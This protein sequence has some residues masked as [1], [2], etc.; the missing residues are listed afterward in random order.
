MRTW[1]KLSA[2][3]VRGVKTPGK[4]Y[5]G[6]GLLLKATEHKG[7]V[8]KAWLFRYQI[9][10]R[11]RQMG[12]GST[13]NV[14]LAE[15]RTK[16]NDKRKQLA[17][18]ID[19]ITARD[20]DRKAARA[21][22]LHRKTFRQCLDGFL[23][24]HGDGWRAKHLKQWQNSMRTYCRVLDHVNVA[25][26]DTAMVMNVIEGGWRRAPETM[27]RVRRRI[28]EILGWA[29]ARGFRPPGSLPTQWKNHLD[30]LLP[31]PRALK[32]VVH[33]PTI[34]YAAA[35]ALYQKLIASGEVAD[36]CLAFLM[37]NASRSIEAR[38]ARWDEIDS[39]SRIWRVPPERMKKRK[40]HRVAL[41]AEAD[42]ALAAKPQRTPVCARRR[43]SAARRHDSAQS[44]L[45]PWRQGHRAWNARRVQNLGR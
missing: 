18:G 12:L 38:G 3:F 4:F 7:V 40:E 21:A 27:D 10:H 9:D 17:A 28:G 13:R 42:R 15:A 8:T 23:A 41:S 30:K 44:A 25:D 43:R 11:E 32:P 33:H 31:H 6:G 5:D 22:E 24:S 19:P 26:I 16:A 14:S 1:D 37:L 36:L 20:A 39:K 34:G 45:P 29:T 2:T 35:P